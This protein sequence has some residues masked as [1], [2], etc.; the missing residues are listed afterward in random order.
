MY[1]NIFD[2][3]P[4]YSIDWEYDNCYNRGLTKKEIIMSKFQEG[5]SVRLG[6]G[7]RTLTVTYV[8]NYGNSSRV[9]AKYD[10]S[11]QTITRY[12]YEF[13]H[14]SQDAP[15]EKGLTKMTGKLFQTREETPRF[16]IGL[17]IDSQGKFVLEMKNGEGIQS[18]DKK[19]IEAVMPFTFS[20]V[21]ADQGKT[22]FNYLG[23]EGAVEVGDLLLK[24]DSRKG[25]T[26]ARVTAVNT[27]SDKATKYFT[28]VKLK[29]ENLELED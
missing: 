6:N 29:T 18:F 5:D 22:E 3:Y 25:F 4:V 19:Q 7:R 8:S 10:H 12:E 28:G 11:S 23:K 2:N 16:G 26:L 14:A 13:V 20:V 24:T 21:F 9:T 17:A 1:S 15:E 27:K